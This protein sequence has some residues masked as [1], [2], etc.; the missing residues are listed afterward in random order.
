VF[1]FGNFNSA[2]SLL[3]LLEH[4]FNP[5]PLG[6]IRGLSLPPQHLGLE[7]RKGASEPLPRHLSALWHRSQGTIKLGLMSWNK[8]LPQVLAAPASDVSRCGRRSH[9]NGL[10][11]VACDHVDMGP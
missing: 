10:R 6:D 5:P 9:G 7:G 11:V 2:A 1:G 3:N 4:L 8:R